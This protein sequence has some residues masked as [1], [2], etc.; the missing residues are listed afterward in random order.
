MECAAVLGDYS[1]GR[2]SSSG[3]AWQILSQMGLEMKQGESNF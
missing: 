1:D 2:P 3:L